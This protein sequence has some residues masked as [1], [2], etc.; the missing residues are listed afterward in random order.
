MTAVQPSPTLPCAIVQLTEGCSPGIQPS[1]RLTALREHSRSCNPARSLVRGQGL[2]GESSLA[3]E[4]LLQPDSQVPVQP[5]GAGASARDQI[6]LPRLGRIN[7][8]GDGGHIPPAQDPW[9]STFPWL[10]LLV[11]GWSVPPGTPCLG[12]WAG[13]PK[14]WPLPVSVPP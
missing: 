1:N 7:E 6:F 4:C 12:S 3:A 8:V 2:L 10:I 13:F 11:P 5:M 14:P 9:A